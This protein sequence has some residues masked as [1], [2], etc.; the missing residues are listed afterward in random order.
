TFKVTPQQVNID[1]SDFDKAMEN[2]IA[3]YH[4]TTFL[5][6]IQGVGRR[7]GGSN[8]YTPGRIRNFVQGSPEYN[9]LFGSYVKQLQDHLEKKGWL[10]KA[11]LYWIDEPGPGIYKKIAEMGDIIHRYAP[12]LKWML[13]EQPEPDLIHSVDIF[14]PL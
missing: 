12:K 6:N 1:F 5:L 2:A 10:D 11:Y 8:G 9:T 13:T 4:L 7:S 14:N 3:K